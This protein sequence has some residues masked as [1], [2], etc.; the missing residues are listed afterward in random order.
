[1]ETQLTLD[2]STEISENEY[3]TLLD[4]YNNL[5]E[6]SKIQQK[7]FIFL[8]ISLIIFFILSFLL[9]YLWMENIY[10]KRL[11]EINNDNLDKIIEFL[12][13]LKR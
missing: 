6:T 10:H 7:T 8:F 13:T 2:H 1:M 9:L 5:K 11:I 12:N 4:K 3:Y